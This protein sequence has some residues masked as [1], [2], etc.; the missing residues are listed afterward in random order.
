LSLEP[1]QQDAVTRNPAYEYYMVQIPAHFSAQ[2]GQVQGQE[3]A[4]YVQEWAN[5]LAAQ[6]WEFYRIDSMSMTVNPGCAFFSSG[7]QFIQYSIMT[8]RRMK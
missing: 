3:I 5:K 7:P 8:F 1:S 6:G 4:A 2:E